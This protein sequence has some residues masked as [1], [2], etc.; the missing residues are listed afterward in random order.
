[1]KHVVR[2]QPYIPTGLL[3][4]VQARAAARSWTVSAVVTDALSQYVERDDSDGPL[5]LRRLDGVTG[6]IEQL[7]RDLEAVAAGFGRFVRFSFFTAP[8][9][10]DDK[11]VKRAE[12]L[13][14]E[15]LGKVGE[16]LRAGTTF[17][18]LVF[19]PRLPPPAPSP[20]ANTEEGSRD[21]GGRS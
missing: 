1:M 17:T 14:R 3:Q 19:P 18:R 12:S 20:P 2:I 7:R 5:L 16:Q 8:E 11:A 10:V 6:A 9:V 13:Y 21:G 4:K 15:F